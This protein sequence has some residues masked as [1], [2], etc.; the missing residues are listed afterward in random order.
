[1][2]KPAELADELTGGSFFDGAK[3]RLARLQSALAA[4]CLDFASG[5][6]SG[7]LCTGEQELHA[8]GQ[9]CAVSARGG[10][11][12]CLS[13]ARGNC[14]TTI[15]RAT[16]VIIDTI[17]DTRHLVRRAGCSTLWRRQSRMAEAPTVMLGWL[18]VVSKLRLFSR[19]QGMEPR[20]DTKLDL[21]SW[22]R[23]PLPTDPC[24][25][26][27]S[28]C[29]PS[30]SASLAALRKRQSSS[31]VELWRLLCHMRLRHDKR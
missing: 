10:G 24:Y 23:H 18:R 16:Q 1:M 17:G 26:R 11:K 8:I 14:S 22:K 5:A 20:L 19:R 27:T 2:L 29:S 4:I 7:R 25:D 30:C 21:F 13:E 28:R 15:L 12:G 3:P 9:R 6:F 31:R